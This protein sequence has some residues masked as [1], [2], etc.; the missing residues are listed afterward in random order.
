LPLDHLLDPH[1]DLVKIEDEGGEGPAVGV[2]PVLEIGPLGRSDRGGQDIRHGSSLS[3]AWTVHVYGLRGEDV[4]RDG[5]TRGTLGERAGSS[6]GDRGGKGLKL[7][8][9]F[10]ILLNRLL[11]TRA[12]GIVHGERAFVDIK[13][14]LY[15]VT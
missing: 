7:G 15:W 3:R 1:V 11:P 14:G 9:G 10:E 12:E 5:G 6:S 8:R 2:D 4:R 13:S